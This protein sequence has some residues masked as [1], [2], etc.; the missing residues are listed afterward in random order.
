VNRRAFAGVVLLVAI[1]LAVALAPLLSPGDPTKTSLKD[2]LLTPSAAHPLGTDALGRDLLARILHG[3]RLSLGIAV[4]VVAV[5]LFVSLPIG[6]SAAYYLGRVDAVVTRVIDILLPFPPILVAIA[7]IS[8]LGPGL[9]SAAF[10]L[11]VSAIAPFVRIVRGAALAVRSE[12]YIEAARAAG[13]ADLRILLRYLLPNALPP[14]VVAASYHLAVSILL[15]AGLGFIG[16]GAQPPVP[17]WGV[18]IS[19][20][21]GYLRTAPHVALFPGLALLLA[22]MGFNLVGDGLNDALNPKLRDR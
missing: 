10:A 17:E 9:T 11:I 22:V 14:I 13:A 19:D 1:G 2:A 16:I 7:L 21:R 5:G 6:A 18:L 12:E 8:I 20:G 4:V 3:G 15:L